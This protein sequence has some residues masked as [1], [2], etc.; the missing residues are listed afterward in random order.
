MSIAITT[1]TGHIGKRLT[2][3]L[4]DAGA[5][6]TLLARNPAKVAGFAA[7][8]A[9]V[10]AGSLEDTSYV[11]QASRGARAL[12]WLTP[13]DFQ[14]A[15][16]RAYQRKL[17]AIAAE[18]VKK[19][20]IG[21]VVVL[22]SVGAHR[23]SGTGPVDG[24]HDV[25]KAVEATGANVLHLRPAFFMENYFW[26][27][28]AIKNAGSVFMPAAGATRLPMIATADIAAAAA[29]HLLKLDWR[30][31]QVHELHGAADIS[32]DEAAATMGRVFGKTIAHVTVPVEA[33][34]AAMQ[35]Q[36]LS[37]SVADGFIQLYKALE[38]GWMAP[39]MPRSQSTTTKTTFETFVGQALKP[40]VMS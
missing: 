29:D 31:R 1:P 11:Q 26:Q 21:H 38:S 17:G 40:A 35:E 8:G 5:Q 2:E 36:G 24:L 28:D 23:G 30:G 13:P 4:L 34:R 14:S 9:K 16:M 18:A 27:L 6:V 19:G 25:E 39:E 3:L 33:A 22:S 15:D 7:R 12:F 20:E 32:F 37:A 10:V